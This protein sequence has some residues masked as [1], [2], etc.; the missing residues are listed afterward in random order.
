MIR[1]GVFAVALLSS[2]AIA[3]AAPQCFSAKEIEAEQ[4]VRFQA[5][6]MV[7][8]DSCGVESY[9]HFTVRNGE[10]LSSYQKEMIEHFRR[11]GP[12][13]AEATFDRY[14]TRL[15]NEASLRV[16]EQA[17]PALCSKSA[18]FLAKADN[19]GKEDFRRYVAQQAAA[20]RKE[21]HSCP[22]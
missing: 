4:A 12:G 21:Y 22:D 6:L 15:A 5:E 2:A 18:E 9:R 17:L 1:G 7:L 16:G 3:Q 10:V 20:R 11:T 19:L 13:R 14:I 8:S